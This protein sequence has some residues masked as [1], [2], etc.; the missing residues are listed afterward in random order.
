MNRKEFVKK[1]GALISVTVMGGISACSEDESSASLSMELVIDIT[2]DPFTKLQE[3]AGWVLHPTEN[4]ILVNW[5][6]Q[7]RA[8]TSVCTHSQCSRNWVFGGPRA[9]CTCHGSQYDFT[10]A[11][12]RGPA[13]DDLVN[14]NVDQSGDVITVSN[15]VS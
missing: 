3:E 8:F 2:Q 13:P 11:V 5:Q 4:V 12:L 10:G 1:T 14:F 15:S 7:I 9:T 6:G